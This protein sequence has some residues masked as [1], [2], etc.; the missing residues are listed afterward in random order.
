[1]VSRTA[2]RVFLPL[3]VGGGIRAVE[4]IRRLL[5]AGADKCSINSAAVARPGLVREAAL[6]FGSQCVVAAVDAKRVAGADRWTV[7]THG[8]R[9]DTGLDA[10]AWCAELASLGAGE[11]LL[12]SMDRDGTGAGFD[13]DLLR[14][15]C[16]AVR[17]PV[18]ASGGVGSLAHFVEGA[19]AGATGL[20]AASVFH[21]GRFSI[22]QVKKELAGAGLPVRLPRPGLRPA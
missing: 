13:L 7:F 3:T 5:L 10:V 6:K 17:V 15:V 1:M 14:R 12:T 4:D 18:I 22:D 2:G 20:L 21:F 16:A 9:Q 19:Q 11:I 8:G